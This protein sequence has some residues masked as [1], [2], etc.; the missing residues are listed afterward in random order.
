MRALILANGDPPSEALARRLAL[1]HDLLLATDG[2]AHRAA[3][4]GLTPDI[5]CGDFDSVR[6]DVARAEFP[7]AE[8]VPTPDQEA[9][10]LEKAIRVARERGAA[11][12]TIIGAGG[13]RVDH[14]LA[15][16]ALLL[17]YH[18]EIPLRI[19]NDSAEAWAVSGTEDAPGECAFPAV[20]GDILSLLSLDGAA[21][22][23][24][25]GV[26]WPLHD[27]SIGIGT[28]GISNV[29]EAEHVTLRVRG[30]AVLVCHLRCRGA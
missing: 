4:L 25:S 30:G 12:I 27:E 17:R 9:S 26:R 1:D 7:K 15:A 24:F 5:L 10:D 18:R 21:R 22:V 14:M 3:G 16:F 23:T 28:R 20:P 13:G 29:A 2:A 19:V 6:L 8:F 11:R